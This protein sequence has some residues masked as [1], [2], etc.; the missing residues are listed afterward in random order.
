MKTL[1]EQV[2]AISKEIHSALLSS[3][4]PESIDWTK[5]KALL[6][7]FIETFG[8]IILPIILSWLQPKPTT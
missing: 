8:P 3:P 1:L 4:N 5:V 7:V 2:D 6:A